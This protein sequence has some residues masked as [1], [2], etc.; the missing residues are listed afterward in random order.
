MEAGEEAY[1]NNITQR[2]HSVK[3]TIAVNKI[4]SGPELPSD[5]VLAVH[6]ATEV[7]EYF[8]NS[9]IMNEEAKMAVGRIARLDKRELET[10][11][12]LG[13]GGF[14]TVWEISKVSLFK[15]KP[16]GNDLMNF[17]EVIKENYGRKSFGIVK[18]G[19]E[20]NRSDWKDTDLMNQ[21]HDRKQ[22]HKHHLRDGISRYAIKMLHSSYESDPQQHFSGII[23][24][25][26]ETRFLSVIRHPNI[27]KMRAISLSDP[28]KSNFFIILDKVYGTLDDKINEVSSSNLLF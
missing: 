21:E 5:D 18:V 1:A 13:K 12:K 8:K 20:D 7:D 28:Y 17:S 4:I 22:I 26:V 27:L 9:K 3:T 24:L 15:A 11:V 2:T 23:D 14:S 16:G 6:V 19:D 25:A 10:G